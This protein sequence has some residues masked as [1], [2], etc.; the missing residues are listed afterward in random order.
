MRYRPLGRTGLQLSVLGL[1]TSPFGGAFGEAD[2]SESRACLHRAIDLGINYIDTSP[3]YGLT[4]SESV[5]GRALRGIPRDRYLLSTKVGRYGDRIED[6]DFSAARV[7]RSIDESLA[8]LGVDHV[9]I[10]LCHDIEFGSIA[11]VID[12][13]IPALREV[14]REGKARFLGVSGLPLKVFRDVLTRTDIDG[15]LS[16]CHLTLSDTTLLDLLPQLEDRQVGVINASPMG[17]GLFTEQGPPSWHPAPARVRE[18][19]RLAVEHCRRRGVNPA[20][21]ALQFAI[22]NDR[23]ASTLV[24]TSAANQIEENVKWIDEPLDPNLLAEIREIL[25][26]IHNVTWPSG[27]PENSDEPR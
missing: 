13:A 25:R 21:L 2:E 3:F 8:R 18:A 10:V 26:P 1:G 15:V 16:Y 27:R 22:G 19:C 14:I 17:M 5:L 12:E 24:G 6:F 23:I 4:R 11:Q 7:K 9:D 20:R